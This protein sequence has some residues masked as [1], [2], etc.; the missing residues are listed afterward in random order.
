MYLHTISPSIIWHLTF[1][2]LSRIKYCQRTLFL[3][4][5]KQIPNPF[6]EF[7]N[8]GRMQKVGRRLEAASSTTTVGPRMAAFILCK[9]PNAAGALGP[10]KSSTTKIVE[11]RSHF[12]C[13]SYQAFLP[14]LSQS[15][16]HIIW[17]KAKNLPFEWTT[18]GRLP[19][20]SQILD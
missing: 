20:Y 16:V 3:N 7:E 2:G 8:K 12:W 15:G 19:D 9:A 6:I 5:L 11:A 13:Q 18:I 1:G 14:L 10:S 4:L 17:G